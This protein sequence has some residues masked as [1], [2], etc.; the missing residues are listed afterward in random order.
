MRKYKSL[1]RENINTDYH[2]R[3][4]GE[5]PLFPSLLDY[6]E[7]TPK[8]PVIQ[9]SFSKKNVEDEG[10]E[11]S[12]LELEKKYQNYLEV[13]YFLS[14]QLVSHQANKKRSV[15]RWYKYKEGFSADLIEYLFKKYEVTSGKIFD[16]FAGSGSALFSA[17]H[18]GFDSCGIELLPIG[19]EL[20]EVREQIENSVSNADLTFMHEAIK[21]IPWTH[22]APK[23]SLNELRITAGAYPPETKDLILRYLTWLINIPETTKGIF[24]FALL[25]IL[26]KI[27]YTRKDGQYL[28]WDYRSGR[29]H[30]NTPF[31]KGQIFDFNDAIIDKLSEMIH[32]ISGII[33]NS[34]NKKTKINLHKGS[35]LEILPKIDEKFDAIITSPPYCNRYDYTRT[36]A[37]ELALQGVD[38]DGLTR[39]RQSML[40]CTVE[41][42]Q[43]DLISLNKDWKKV[44]SIVDQQSTLQKILTYL[45]QKKENK[46]LNN[47]GIA[48]MVRGYFYELACVIYECGRVLRKD[49]PM[50]MVNDNVKYAGV[51]IPV[52]LILSDI[53]SSLGFDIEK[54]LVLPTG[55]GNSSQQMGSHGREALRKC[56]YIWKKN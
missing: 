24:R 13:D 31:D 39:L 11:K 33:S 47:D 48:R 2:T 46:E 9:V 29:K 55:K 27:S 3:T 5:L 37:L 26:E 28:R 38:Q 43:K 51:A 35:C 49:A 7:E 19:S 45:D 56:V 10:I 18:L 8:A 6:N 23:L 17:K 36:Y 53:A 15:Y 40:S 42:R 34:K 30:G 12:I 25:C 54:V 21:D 14:R 44:I 4:M 52:D 50:I 1:Q 20:I 22:C 32:D 16:P 41:N